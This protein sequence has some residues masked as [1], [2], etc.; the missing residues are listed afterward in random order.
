MVIAGGDPRA[1]LDQYTATIRSMLD[2]Y[3]GTGPGD[4]V[5]GVVRSVSAPL[6]W[7]FDERARSWYLALYPG[8][9]LWFF[10][11]PTVLNGVRR[12]R[13]TAT[14]IFL[15]ITIAS[16]IVMSSITAGFTI[17]QRS[18]VEPLVV[19]LAVAGLESWRRTAY[20]GSIALLAMAVVAGAHSRSLVT[21]LVIV[22]GATGVAFVARR[23][24]AQALGEAFA[25]RVGDSIRGLADRRRPWLREF[26]DHLREL[27]VRPV[28]LRTPRNSTSNR[29][30]FSLI[31]VLAREMRQHG[32]RTV[33][34]RAVGE[35]RGLTRVAPPLAFFDR[36]RKT[37]RHEE[38]D[39]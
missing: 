4:W 26:I 15:G 9:W 5:L 2:L 24:P 13:L 19:V 6:P 1:A 35:G 32:P 11:L 10:L 20:R 25:D 8:M 22:A 12:L 3:G 16:L 23:L 33:P 29:P 38:N 31:S 17:R 14:M 18:A 21:A 34:L 30:L 37:A 7:V 27:A 36:W 28:P 39:A